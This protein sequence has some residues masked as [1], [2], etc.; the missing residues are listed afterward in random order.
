M[1]PDI[2]DLLLACAARCQAAGRLPSLA[3]GVVQGE[4]LTWWTGRGSTDGTLDGPEPDAD[5]QYRIGS[6]TKTF[7][8]ILVLR[9][10][11]EGLVAIL[12]VPL[13]RKEEG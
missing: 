2:E 10:R 8:A 6:I 4:T 3:A 1:R 5:T 7:V 12:G 9:L 11:D 13:L